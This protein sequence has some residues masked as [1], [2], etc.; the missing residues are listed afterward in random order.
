MTGDNVTYPNLN[1]VHDCEKCHG[2]MVVISV[3]I[4][5]NTRCGYCREIVDYR[6]FIEKHIPHLTRMELSE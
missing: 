4:M 3:D 6:K 2:K 5:G 1:E